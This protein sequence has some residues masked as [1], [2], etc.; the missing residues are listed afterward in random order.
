MKRITIT[1]IALFG[2]FRAVAQTNDFFIVKEYGSYSWDTITQTGVERRID[3]NDDGNYDIR[4]YADINWEEMLYPKLF[5]HQG[6][7]FHRMEGHWDQIQN[8]FI[9]FNTPFNDSSLT[10]NPSIFPEMAWANY[11]RYD[12]ITFRSG[13]REGT[14]GEYYYGWVE[15]YAVN[16]YDTV[17]F[18]VERTCYCTIPNYPLRW[19]QTTCVGVQEIDHNSFA[20]IHPNPTTDR[21]TVEGEN[22]QQA[23]VYDILGQLIIPRSHQKWRMLL[24]QRRNVGVL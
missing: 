18:H 3:I 4:Y 2:L 5:A 7:C 20:T 21:F 1:L 13:I 10:W 17:Y 8:T 9:D 24:I 14:E 16:T 12:T 11:H 22:L 23:E 15:V 19:G 6:A